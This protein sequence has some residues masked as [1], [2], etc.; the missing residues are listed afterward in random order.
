M[1]PRAGARVELDPDVTDDAGLPVARIFVDE[2]TD[3]I[4]RAA[5]LGA[6]A[7]E[8][9]G[10]LGGGK[11]GA[12]ELRRTAF[13]Q[14]GTCRMGADPETSVAGADG[15]VRGAPGVYVVDGAALPT[16]GGVPP[17]L[18]IMANAL[19]IAETLV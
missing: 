2:Q 13:L 16:L 12:G 10:R 6:T 5:V 8:V 19:R 4:E 7:R 9:L 3:E 15:A 17:T 1:R 11:I 18:T 14:G